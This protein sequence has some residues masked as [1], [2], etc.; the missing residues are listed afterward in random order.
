MGT[1]PPSWGL[2]SNKTA[3][4][5]SNKMSLLMQVKSLTCDFGTVEEL[6]VVPLTQ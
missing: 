2:M 5:I 1:I 3:T 4:R 6:I